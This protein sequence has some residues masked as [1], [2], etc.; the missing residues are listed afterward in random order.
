MDG[1]LEIVRASIGKKEKCRRQ[2]SAEGI[3]L[4]GGV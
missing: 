2:E 3:T 4:D 1:E